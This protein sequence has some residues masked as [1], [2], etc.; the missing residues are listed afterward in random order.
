MD[1]STRLLKNLKIELS[2]DPALPLLGI[3]RNISQYT[4]EILA[5]PCLLQHNSQQVSY[6]INPGAHQQMNG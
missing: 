5:Y 4:I 6:G 1:I 2:Y 3:Q